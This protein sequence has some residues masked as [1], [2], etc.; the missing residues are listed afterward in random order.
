METLMS[1]LR[2][3]WTG[4]MILL[5]VF[6][7]LNETALCQVEHET[8]REAVAAGSQ[9]LRKKEYEESIPHLEAALELAED[10]SQ[11][12]QAYEMLMT[13]Y[14]ELPDSSK[15]TEACEFILENAD[16]TAKRSIVARSFVSFIHNRG[17]TKTAIDDYEKTLKEKP[18]SIVA[19]NILDQIYSRVRRDK[20]NA[21]RIQAQLEKV[22]HERATKKA[23]GLEEQAKASTDQ[24]AALWKDAG[25]AWLEADNQERGLAAANASLAAPPENRS[26]LLVYFWRM[27]LGDILAGA[28]DTSRAKE[29]Y[30]LS[31]DAVTQA[32]LKKS[33]QDKLDALNAEK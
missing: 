26:P 5:V 13:P 27:S 28:G 19:L 20:E 21:A 10:D 18:D 2:N 16:T 29:Q 24:A 12:L 32:A 6:S 33:P 7:C 4:T 30:Q 25:L 22:N 8:F 1:T 14:R 9:L 3:S 17:L 23:E 31:I 15:M 11:R